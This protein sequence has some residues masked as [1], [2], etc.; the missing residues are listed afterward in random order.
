MIPIG[1]ALPFTIDYVAFDLSSGLPVLSS[2]YDISNGSATLIDTVILDDLSNG[3]Y[4]DT[5]TG[6]PTKSFLVISA[7]YMDTSYATLNPL[8]S[9]KAEIYKS[10]DAP[11]SFLA[12]NYGLY[13]EDNSAFLAGIVYDNTTGTPNMLAMIPMVN[14]IAGVYFGT[15]TGVVN[16]TYQV[17]KYVYDDGTYASINT[18]YAPGSDTI[19]LVQ[20]TAVILNIFEAA[21]LDGQSLPNSTLRGQ[22]LNATLTESINP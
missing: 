21:T 9:P 13:T 18:A 19:V 17:A 12:F 15:F 5:Y 16:H 1:S 8:Y 22:I 11:E 2:I 3:I 6:L 4:T 20:E 14:V 7:V 10:S